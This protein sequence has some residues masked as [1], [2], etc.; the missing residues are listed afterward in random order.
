MQ[1]YRVTGIYTAIVCINGDETTGHGVYAEIDVVV[2]A[3][4]EDDARSIAVGNDLA[5][6]YEDCEVD[7]EQWGKLAVSAVDDA[8]PEREQD[9]AAVERM[10]RIEGMPTLFDP[11]VR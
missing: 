11:Q 10:M 7:D 3:N 2:A 6:R 4:D 9:P 5:M 8:S 1:K